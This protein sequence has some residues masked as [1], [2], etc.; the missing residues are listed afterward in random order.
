MASQRVAAF[1]AEVARSSS[2]HEASPTA[3][4][5]TSK[6]MLEAAFSTPPVDSRRTFFGN[7]DSLPVDDDAIAVTVNALFTDEDGMNA[8]FDDSPSAWSDRLA[9]HKSEPGSLRE[10][11]H[12]VRDVSMLEV[13]KYFDELCLVEVSPGSNKDAHIEHGM[14]RS[15]EAMLRIGG[16]VD[17]P[18]RQSADTVVAVCQDGVGT[19]PAS[20]AC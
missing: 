11:F 15:P 12:T 16:L 5:R 14:L 13:Q 18:D 1:R 6:G 20:C 17:S 7:P 8:A 4:A 10:S 9:R 3:E 2:H 19:N